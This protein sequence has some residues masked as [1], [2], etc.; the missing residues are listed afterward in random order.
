MALAGAASR[1]GCGCGA[2]G[3]VREGGGECAGAR[4]ASSVI[5]DEDTADGDLKDQ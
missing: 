4:D 3:L 2:R 1:H 5:N